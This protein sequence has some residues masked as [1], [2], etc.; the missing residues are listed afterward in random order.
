MDNAASERPLADE[1]L[2]KKKRKE[3]KVEIFSRVQAENGDEMRKGG[4]EWERGQDEW[5]KE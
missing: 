2:W 5:E 3:K 1:S 4:W